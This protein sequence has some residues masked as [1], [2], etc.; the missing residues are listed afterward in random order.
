MTE[1]I[2]LEPASVSDSWKAILP[3]LVDIQTMWPQLNNWTIEEVYDKLL[4]GDAVLYYVPEDGFAIC[5]PEYD[6]IAGETD[7]FIWIAFSFADRGAGMI[8][9]YLPSFIEIAGK[10]GY[11]GVSTV[12]LHPALARLMPLQYSRFKVRVNEET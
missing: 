2:K 1:A 10:L 6:D 3:Y 5:T 4:K 9:K 11:A 7:L 12:S 8:Q